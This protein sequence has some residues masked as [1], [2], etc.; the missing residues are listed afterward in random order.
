MW[1]RLC[2]FCL[3]YNGPRDALPQKKAGFPCSDL[4]AGS[5]FISQNERMSE[6]PVES[7]EKAVVLNLFW[8]EG[9]TSIWDFE[10]CAE[11]S[12]S[13]GNDAWLFMKIDRNTYITLSTNK[14]RLASRSPPE[15]YVFSCQA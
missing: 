3:K 9:L 5:S 7:L 15:A 2:V 14:G 4:N 1:E 10:T 6:S 11:F 13:K 8:T 12:A